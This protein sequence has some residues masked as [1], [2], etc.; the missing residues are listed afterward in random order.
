M[1]EETVCCSRLPSAR[2]S[3]PPG[4]SFS[5]SACSFVEPVASHET[6][7]PESPSLFSCCNRTVRCVSEAA[8]NSS[9]SILLALA[10][11]S[12]FLGLKSLY[13]ALQ[14]TL[15]RPHKTSNITLF[16]PPLPPLLLDTQVA[17][18]IGSQSESSHPSRGVSSVPSRPVQSCHAWVSLGCRTSSFRRVRSTLSCQLFQTWHTLSLKLE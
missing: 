15:G 13:L 18:C 12:I 17:H 2:L 5:P 16:L 14:L 7:S 3:H 9:R 6:V 4:L 8:E 11:A 10:Q 1:N